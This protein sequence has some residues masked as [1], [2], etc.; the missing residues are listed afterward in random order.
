MTD[1]GIGE[2]RLVTVAVGDCLVELRLVGAG[3]DQRQQV[4]LVHDPPLAEGDLD[5]L[6]LDLA[7]HDDPVVG[8]DGADAAQIELYDS[9]V[10]LDLKFCSCP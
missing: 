6:P 1:V 8:I 9:S 7:A 2:Q 10:V 4:A 3:V 5:Q